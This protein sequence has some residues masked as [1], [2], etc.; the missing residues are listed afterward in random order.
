MAEV[1]NL[2]GRGRHNTK[3]KTA[4]EIIEQEQQGY[5]RVKNKQQ[6][7]GRDFQ[8]MPGLPTLTVQHGLTKLLENMPPD[9]L[10]DPEIYEGLRLY[11]RLGAQFEYALKG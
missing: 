2:W 6:T 10:N 7:E 1:I 9:L 11:A 4:A 5:M 3:P 8:I